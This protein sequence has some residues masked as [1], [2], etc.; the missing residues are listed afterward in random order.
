MIPYR[1]VNDRMIL[2]LLLRLRFS[3]V[4]HA[5]CG[6]TEVDLDEAAVEEDLGAATGQRCRSGRRDSRVETKVE[7]ELL[8]VAEEC[9][10]GRVRER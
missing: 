6:L 1:V 2:A 4:L 7:A 9:Q 5:S 3:E 10:M 8:V